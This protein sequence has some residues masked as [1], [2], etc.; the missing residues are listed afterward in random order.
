MAKGFYI[1][2]RY[3]KSV[4]QACKDSS[5]NRYDLSANTIYARLKSGMN[6]E[7]AFKTPSKRKYIQI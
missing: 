5:L 6:I 4:S 2:G 7:E 1:N 3:Y